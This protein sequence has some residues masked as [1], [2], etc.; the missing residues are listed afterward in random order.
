MF[1]SQIQQHAIMNTSTDDIMKLYLLTPLTLYI[2][3]HTHTHT[4]TRGGGGGVVARVCVCVCVC[5]Y[6]YSIYIVLMVSKDYIIYIHKSARGSDKFIKRR[7]NEKLGEDQC[8][9]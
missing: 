8:R 6:A 3:T 5:V 9:C 4:H 7:G 1:G 2:Y